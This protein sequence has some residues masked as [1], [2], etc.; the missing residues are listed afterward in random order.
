MHSSILVAALAALVTGQTPQTPAWQTDYAQAK[1]QGE[2]QK[3]PLAVFLGSGE[4]GWEKVA[5]DGGVN[6]QAQQILTNRYVPLYID[7][8]TDAGSELAHAF[9]VHDG[10]GLVI[11]DRSGQFISFRQVGDMTNADLVRQ[12][13]TLA[14]NNSRTS[15]YPST[16]TIT[17]SLTGYST[18]SVLQASSSCPNCSGGYVSTGG[19]MRLFRR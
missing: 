8:T 15:F 6:A 9:A 4:R 13:D 2:S 18:G 19:G 7:T 14:S 16:G 10:Q 3:K 5:R 17:N 1:V 12:L 11:S